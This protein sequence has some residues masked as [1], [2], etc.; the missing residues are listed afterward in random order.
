MTR[1]VSLMLI[2]GAILAGPAFAGG[3]VQ[4]A[5]ERYIAAKLDCDNMSQYQ[6]E[7]CLRSAEEAYKAATAVSG[8]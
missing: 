2:A 4:P 7:V 8:A 3:E 1:N 6:K 5:A